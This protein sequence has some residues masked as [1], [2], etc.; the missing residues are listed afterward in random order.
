MCGRLGSHTSQYAAPVRKRPNASSRAGP[1]TL[2]VGLCAGG[3]ELAGAEVTRPRGPTRGPRE[4]GALGLGGGEAGAVLCTSTDSGGELDMY[5]RGI[6][7]CNDVCGGPTIVT[8]WIAIT[9][10]PES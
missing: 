9:V 8:R 2:S 7:K 5:S 4:E 10:A 6:G 1:A 3:A